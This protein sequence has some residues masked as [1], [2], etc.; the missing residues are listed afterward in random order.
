[1]SVIKD[2]NGVRYT[3]FEKEWTEITKV[4]FYRLGIQDSERLS[5]IEFEGGEREFFKVDGVYVQKLGQYCGSKWI[6]QYY[7]SDI[8]A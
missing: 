2:L 1:M 3:E 4:F 6:V 7:I 5:T 8:N